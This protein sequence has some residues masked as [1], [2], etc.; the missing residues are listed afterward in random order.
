MSARSANARS[1][2]GGPVRV[3]CTLALLAGCVASSAAQEPPPADEASE[4]ALTWRAGLEWITAVRGI[5][6]A[7]TPLNPGNATFRV[8]QLVGVTEVRPNLRLEAG[9]RLQLVFRPR[10]RGTIE[11]SW[12][13]GADRRDRA[14]GTANVTELY[15]SWRVTDTVAVAYGLQNFQWG[16]AELL[17]PSNRIFHEVGLFRDPLYYVRGRHLARVNVSAGRQWSLVALAEVGA[18]SEEAFRAGEH[19]ERAG[20]VKAEFTT[21]SGESYVGVTAGGRKHETPWFGEYA[22][23]T[24]VAG[25]SIYIDASHQSGSLAWYPVAELGLGPGARGLDAGPAEAGHDGSPGLTAIT[26]GP[27][28]G[29]RSPNARFAQIDVGSDRLRTLAIGGLR[30]AFVNGVD[31]RVEYLHQDAGYDRSELELAPVALASQGTREAVD[32]WLKPG[33]EFLGRRL[34]LASIRV[35]DLAPAKR[36][37]LQVRYLAS[38]TDDSGVA[39]ATT[40]I[41]AGDAL[42][43]FA[44]VTATHGSVTAEFSRLVRASVVGGAVWSW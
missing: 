17:S 23:A 3:L 25:L 15:V 34:A 44:S 31:A 14:E 19:F 11:S 39:F 38:L 32:Q 33:L 35:P 18:T 8:P 6:P 42:V 7:D 27:E 9:S 16:P 40:S 28:P 29:A 22:S 1:E 5:D 13:D 24:L 21:S 20:Q 30:Y 43:L 12:V 4:R 26:R 37:D 41:E 36:L 10:W 2:A